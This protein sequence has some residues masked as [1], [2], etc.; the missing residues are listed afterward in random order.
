MTIYGSPLSSAFF[1]KGTLRG[2]IGLQRAL[3]LLLVAT[4]GGC[5]YI[6]PYSE[7]AYQ[8]ATTLKV[9]TLNVMT[10]A[11]EPYPQHE[12]EV[13][14]LLDRIEKAHQY[15]AGM[16]GNE[17]SAKQ[18]EILADSNRNLV[19]GFMK[20]WREDGKLGGVFVGEAK[21]QVGQAYD[22]IIG[23]ESGK[24]KPDQVSNR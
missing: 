13:L 7:H 22:D 19:G 12:S 8:T 24:L 17:L 21:G 9:D 15:A 2:P 20:R 5:H 23:L 4:T 6:S 1:P 16:P 11:T 10:H 18:W 14:A 3:I